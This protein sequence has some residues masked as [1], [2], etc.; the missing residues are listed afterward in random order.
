MQA[1]MSILFYSKKAKATTDGL[2]PIYQRITID[3]HRLE[4]STKRYV[5]IAKWITEAG[6]MKGNSEEARA[7]NIYLDIL[8]SKV[9]DYQKE[10]L[11]EE[12]FLNVENMRNKILGTTEKARMLVAIFQDHNN[13]IE[14]LLGD[15]FAPGTLDRYKTSLKHT[16]GFMQWK[17]NVSDIDIK[18]IDHSFI[19]DYEFYLCSVSKCA[20]NTAVK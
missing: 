9:Y 6:K 15:E 14:A 13:R 5:E 1:K 16:I 17:F 4:I 11:H 2:V 20:N 18:R 10:I 12:L 3:G 8:R 7:L 19:T